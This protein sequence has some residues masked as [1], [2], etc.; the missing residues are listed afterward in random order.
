MDL[1]LDLGQEAAVT[2]VDFLRPELVALCLLAALLFLVGWGGLRARKRAREKLVS[3]R[4]ARRFLPAFSEGRTRLRVVLASTALALLA[5]GL[6][7]PVRGYTLR[8]VQRKGLDLV[9]CIDTSRSMLV[10]D[11]RPDRLTRA[12]REVS[13]LIDRLRGDR[14]ALI[15]F[16]GEP[17]EIAPLT[18]DRTT[19]RALLKTI[20]PDDNTRGGTDLGAALD[21]ALSMFDGRT[22]SH[23]AIV[24]LT[25]GEDLEAHG[26]QIA[27]QAAESGIR[28]YVVGMGTVEGGKNPVTAPDGS[29]TFLVDN[30]GGEVISALGGSGLEELARAT[31]GDYLAATRVAAP[32]EELYQRRISRLE[33]RELGG[34]QESVPHDRFQWVLV[35]ALACMLAEAGLRE[36][37]PRV[38]RSSAVVG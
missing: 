32:L 37:R 13:G 9:V 28:I 6:A 21:R 30:Q 33:G 17:R 26:L 5:L 23:E 38:R 27:Q 31:G 22:G 10:R 14:I 34:G 15:A 18:H 29:Q 8:A 3:A 25:D 20:S 1:D 19:L 4:H 11:L 7:G 24:L 35:L 36:R 2:G 16:S 12:I